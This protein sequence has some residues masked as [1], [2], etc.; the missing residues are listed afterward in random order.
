MNFRRKI[1]R[2]YIP[3]ALALLLLAAAAA[4]FLHADR[5]GHAIRVALEAALHRD[6]EIGE[7]R[8]TLVRGPAFAIGNVV[9]HEDPAFGI[10]PLAYVERLEA[11]P[12]LLALLRGRLEFASLR[13]VSPSVNLAKNMEPSGRWNFE[14][15]IAGAAIA[16]L[17]NIQMDTGRINFKIGDTKSVFYFMNTDLEISSP[18]LSGMGDLRFSGEAARADRASRGLG[19]FTGR[20]HY[21]ESGVDLNLQLEKTA[22]GEITALIYGRDAGIHG[23]I[24][25]R[26][27]LSGPLH[28]AKIRGDLYLEDVHRWDLMPPHGG[29]WN[30]AFQGRLNFAGQFLELESFSQNGKPLPLAVRFRASDYLSQP[31]WGVSVNCNRL[32][33]EPLIEVARHMGAGLPENWTLAGNVEG[34][35]SYSHPGDWQGQIVFQ[36]ASFSLFDAPALRMQRGRMFFEGGRVRLAS[37]SVHAVDG[38]EAT[39]DGAYDLDSQAFHFSITTESMNVA[40]LRAQVALAAVPLLEQVRTGSWKGRLRYDRT[41]AASGEP[42]GVRDGWSGRFQLT[43][44]EIP[45]PGIPKPLE[46]ASANIALNGPRLEVDRLH[47]AVGEIRLQGDY[48]Y[49]PRAVRPHRFRLNVPELDVEEL[50]RLFLPTLRRSRGIIARTLGITR[51][52]TPAWLRDRHASG[53]IRVAVLRLGDLR[54]DRF[55]THVLWDGARVELGE[56]GGHWQGASANGRVSI[57]LTESAPVYRST[58]DLNSAGWKG[59][60]LDLQVAL[61]TSGIGNE[62]LSNLESHGSFRAQS[63]ELPPSASISAASGSYLLNW[64]GGSPRLQ[65]SALEAVLDDVLYSG[66]GVAQPDGRLL[67]QLSNGEK[68]LRLGGT[69][70]RLRVEQP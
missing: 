22:I 70:A 18:G 48:R 6:V 28:D 39:L 5:F 36:E 27:H 56:A 7:V 44:A 20:G 1:L 47:A 59:G 42:A 14:G 26:A 2:R 51:S 45:I 35:V 38:D 25:S 33:V 8:F 31:R 4:P 53:T 58:F 37:S 13:L 65:I 64:E 29:G 61:E 54:L 46:V 24:S 57:D 63:L 67:L 68:Q 23:L 49:E 60:K 40:S 32:P 66:R 9:I 62:L 19:N 52:G 16:A 12:S 11:R 21:G 69:L 50:E 30:L 41:V 15:L 55:Q 43:G 3:A 34:A 17:P 10:E